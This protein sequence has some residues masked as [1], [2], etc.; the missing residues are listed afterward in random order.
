MADRPLEE[1]SDDLSGALQRIIDP[2]ADVG[3]EDIKTV[4]VHHKQA[5]ERHPIKFLHP[6]QL[7]QLT[8]ILFNTPE[9]FVC[10]HDSPLPE[11][12]LD[13]VQGRKSKQTGTQRERE[14]MTLHG[15]RITKTYLRNKEF[16][17]AGREL[18][19]AKWTWEG[20]GVVVI[21]VKPKRGKV[22]SGKRRSG[23]IT[24]SESRA[25]AARPAWAGFLVPDDD[26]S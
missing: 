4:L 17:H 25:K 10:C 11:T 15:D 8:R 7:A 1:V 9:C 19:V 21:V 5:A 18:S 22:H 6:D 3:A 24:S 23:R 16:V 2:I 26:L 13:Y 20:H 14:H 12:R